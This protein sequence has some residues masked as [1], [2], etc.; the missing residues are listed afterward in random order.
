MTALLESP[1]FAPLLDALAVRGALGS[2]ELSAVALL[3]LLRLLPLVLLSTLFT[4]LRGPAFFGFSA[5]QAVALL[6]LVLGLLPSALATHAT[7]P[8]D[9][10]SL[11]MLGLREL[12]IGASFAVAASVPL[13]AL[14]QL[15]P[16]VESVLAMQSASLRDAFA[17]FASALFVT[18]GGLRVVV[19][20]F[21]RSL[22]HA[23]IGQSI[24][25]E[26][27]LATLDGSAHLLAS[28]LALGVAFASP[29]L[30]S[31]VVVQVGLALSARAAGVDLTFAERPF[32]M[33]MVLVAL[34][35]SLAWISTA[36]HDALIA[37][38]AV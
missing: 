1:L 25:S 27:L 33:A 16:S 32:R 5:V 38:L 21:A 35:A 11:F 17:L 13:L 7:L 24:A 2:E 37:A 30:V 23:P 22:A 20:A 29:V 36:L 26:N 31:V 19:A 9:A 18:T 34:M 3:L 6:A 28:V 14:Q 15:G 10:S 4:S 8:S 12:V